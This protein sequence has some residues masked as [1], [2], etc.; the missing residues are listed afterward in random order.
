MRPKPVKL[1]ATTSEQTIQL[2]PALRSMMLKNNGGSDVYIDFD[3]AID[4]DNSY[5]LEAG[6][7]LTI[8]YNFINLHYQGVNGTATLYML[9]IIQ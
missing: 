5:V 4:T 7:T 8:D 1:S 9:K 2:G 3:N 6:E